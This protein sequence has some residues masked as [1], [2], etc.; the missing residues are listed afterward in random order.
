MEREEGCGRGPLGGSEWVSDEVTSG[1]SRC[2]A[3]GRVAGCESSSHVSK[4]PRAPR[5]L[6]SSASVAGCAVFVHNSRLA[7]R[8]NGLLLHAYDAIPMGAWGVG[9]NSIC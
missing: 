6:L 8:N 5:G 2:A 4:M 1:A 7:L 3:L 9:R